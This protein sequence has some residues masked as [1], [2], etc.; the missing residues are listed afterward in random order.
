MK[1]KKRKENFQSGLHYREVNFEISENHIFWYKNDLPSHNQI[2]RNFLNK[3][4][5][6][7]AFQAMHCGKKKREE[8]RRNPIFDAQSII[9]FPTTF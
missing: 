9:F 3:Y 6:E 4:F 8:A 5:H 1:E 7:I 2:K